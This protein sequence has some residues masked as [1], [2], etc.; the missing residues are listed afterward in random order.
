M[1]P[2]PPCHKWG[3]RAPHQGT[4]VHVPYQAALQAAHACT[5]LSSTPRA[6]SLAAAAGA[7]AAPRTATQRL[8]RSARLELRKAALADPRSAARRQTRT[9]GVGDGATAGARTRHAALSAA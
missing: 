6:R 8:F 9:L 7:A 3:R 5:G 4:H 1:A 2:P